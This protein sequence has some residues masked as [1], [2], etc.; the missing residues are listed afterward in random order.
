MQCQV[1]FDKVSINDSYTKCKS[2]HVCC[3]ECINVNIGI[4]IAETKKLEC[5]ECKT[6]YDINGNIIPETTLI[7]YNDTLFEISLKNLNIKKHFFL[8]LLYCINIILRNNI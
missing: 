5:F 8:D 6:D 2:K 3:S 7:K 1:C 4:C